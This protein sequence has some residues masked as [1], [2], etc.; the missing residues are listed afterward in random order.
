MD[1][2]TI[3]MAAPEKLVLSVLDVNKGQISF[4]R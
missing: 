3:R 1:E 2:I 4:Q